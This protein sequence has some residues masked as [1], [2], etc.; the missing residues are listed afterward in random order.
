MT[1]PAGRLGPGDL[2]RFRDLVREASGLELPQARRSDLQRAVT[3]ALAAT[4]LGDPGALYRHLR[5]PAGRADLEAFVADLT[6]GETHF[7]RNRP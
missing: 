6:V 5:G 7:F 1:V 4:G 2:D 3:R